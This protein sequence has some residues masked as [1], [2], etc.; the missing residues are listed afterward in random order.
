MMKKK[1]CRKNASE[2]DFKDSR[3][4]IGKEAI[5]AYFLKLLYCFT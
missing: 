3:K 5:D 2:S 1:H 4:H